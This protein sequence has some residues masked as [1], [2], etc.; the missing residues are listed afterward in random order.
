MNVLLF[1]VKLWSS[2]CAFNLSSWKSNPKKNSGLNG[3]RIFRLLKLKA[4]S[5][6]HN[7]THVYPQF[8][9]MI[10]IYSYSYIFTIIGYMTN[11]QLNIYPCGLIAQWVEHCT[12]IARSWVRIPFKPEFF[13]R[14]LFQLLKLKAR[15]EDHNFTHVYPQFTYMIFIYSYSFHFFNRFFVSF[16]N[17]SFLLLPLAIFFPISRC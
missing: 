11:S 9:Y 13:F 6:D 15:C 2:Q 17:I 10:F 3:I 5:E 12:G 7:F 16:L 4:H 14:L 8:T 1:W